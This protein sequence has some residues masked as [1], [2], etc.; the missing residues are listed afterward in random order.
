MD[1]ETIRLDVCGAQWTTLAA[2]V[3]VLTGR[4][5]SHGKDFAAGARFHHVDAGYFIV[6]RLPRLPSTHSTRE[7]P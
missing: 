2:G 6:R 4:G 5:K 3:L 1:F 7:S